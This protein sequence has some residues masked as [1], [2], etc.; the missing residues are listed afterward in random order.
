[1]K[2]IRRFTKTLYLFL[3][4]CVAMIPAHQSFSQEGMET[5]AAGLETDSASIAATAVLTTAEFIPAVEDEI[6][7]ARLT[8]L[9]KDIKLSFNRTVRGFIDYFT[10]KNRRYP[11]VME[12]R[13]NLYFPIFEEL[14]KKHSM[15]DE[16]KYLAIVESGLN[17]RAVSRVGAAGLWQFMP[18]TGREYSLNQDEYIDERLDP[19]K[20]TEAACMYLK[21]AYRVFGDW[22][23][24]I[25]SY[26]CGMGNVRR[27]IKRSGYRDSFWEVYN[28]L[29]QETRSYVPQFIALTYVMNHLK[30]HNI[31]ADSIEYPMEYD[32]IMVNK[33]PMN[34]DVLCTQLSICPDDFLKLNPAIKKNVIP[35]KFRYIVRIPS[36]KSG[37]LS[38]N[39]VAIMDSC[40]KKYV[41]IDTTNINESLNIALEGIRMAEKPIVPQKQK[42]LYTVK[43]GDVLNKISTKYAVSTA[44]IK[45]WNKIKSNNLKVGQ[46]LTIYKDSRYVKVSAKSNTKAIASSKKSL[47]RTKKVQQQ[48]KVQPGDTLWTISQKYDGISVEK[49]KKL[50]K[51]KSNEI[52]PGQKLI[53]G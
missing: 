30:D 23:L 24:A 12:R 25:A 8:S 2:Q 14:L 11:L 38:S 51:L 5:D 13:R 40:S 22:E 26:N 7:Q 49:I 33:Q 32:T 4:I 16:L 46:R 17:P 37:L 29:P 48:Y 41:V 45:K 36:D 52:K 43:R 53:L 34:L 50:N 21:E 44:D 9:Q 28:H 3:G 47:Q 6:L 39:R 19:Y 15:P 10:I 20:S 1:M 42:F 27:A 31:V 35:A 18:V